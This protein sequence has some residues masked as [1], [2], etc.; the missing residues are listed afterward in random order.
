MLIWLCILLLASDPDVPFCGDE[1][2]LDGPELPPPPPYWIL[3][4]FPV[5]E[6]KWSKEVEWSVVGAFVCP[7][8]ALRSV[9]MASRVE[10]PTVRRA[11]CLLGDL[12]VGRK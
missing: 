9:K 6:R 5:L 1:T 2:R 8:M 3:L 11:Y 10:A 4:L 7:S 12:G